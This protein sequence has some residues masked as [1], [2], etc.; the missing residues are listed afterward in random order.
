ME[1]VILI[2]T[3]KKNKVK[4]T[5]YPE[6]QILQWIAN[7]KTQNDGYRKLFDI[8]KEPLYWYLRKVLVSHEDTNDALQNTFLK[9]FEKLSTFEGRSSLKTWMYSIAYREALQVIRKNKQRRYHAG[10]L[11][12]DE[13]REKVIAEP[14]FNGNE[15]HAQL[16]MA[17][18]SL[19]DRQKQIFE[20]RYFEEMPYKEIGVITGLS[21]GGIKASF[22]HAVKKIK[23]Y[24][25]QN[26]L[27]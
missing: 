17:V 13:G 4:V 7:P 11:N 21:E 23:D 27:L 24:M 6:E 25:T 22:H 15:I 5:E 2:S 10:D 1:D 18:R 3:S 14:Y 19:P 9:V 20:L 8:Y 26:T 16:I 12:I